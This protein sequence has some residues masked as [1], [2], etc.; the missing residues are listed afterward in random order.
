MTGSL[1]SKYALVEKVELSQEAHQKGIPPG[2][3][4]AVAPVQAPVVVEKPKAPAA[5][6]FSATVV[7]KPAL[8]APVEASK[9]KEQ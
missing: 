2:P 9:A 5:G 4:H 6:K 8:T 7:L 1:T 3:P